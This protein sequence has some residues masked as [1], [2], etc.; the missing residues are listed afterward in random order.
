MAVIME[1]LAIASLGL[2]VVTFVITIL[3]QKRAQWKESLRDWSYLILDFVLRNEVRVVETRSKFWEKNIHLIVSE[4]EKLVILDAYQGH[5]HKF[6]HALERRLEQAEPFHLVFL[7]LRAGD[8]FFERCSRVIGA[9]E[10]F[11]LNVT[12]I[13][14]ELILTLKRR[15]KASANKHNKIL[16]FYYWEGISPGPLMSWTKNGKEKIAMG[17]WVNLSEATDGTPYL[18]VQRGPL[19]DALKKHYEAIIKNARENPDAPILKRSDKN[20]DGP[21]AAL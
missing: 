11:S 3:V 13:D 4:S 20:V 2:T 9:S 16:E 12:K 8:S 6:W 15:V 7:M 17:L 10:S 14:K 21:T 5:K 19:F 1:V 18:I